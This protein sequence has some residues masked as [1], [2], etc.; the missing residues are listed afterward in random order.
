MFTLSTKASW[1]NENF[2]DQ[3]CTSFSSQSGTRDLQYEEMPLI[4]IF[5]IY[6]SFCS[7]LI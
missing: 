5:K 7:K 3:N 4:S 2:L 1:S 6:G